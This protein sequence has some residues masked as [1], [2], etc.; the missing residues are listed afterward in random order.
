MQ[1]IS[2]ILFKPE[3]THILLLPVFWKIF[4]FPFPL[5]CSSQTEPPSASAYISTPP[6]LAGDYDFGD[7]W[8]GGASLDWWGLQH[9]HITDVLYQLLLNFAINNHS[10]N[11]LIPRLILT[12]ENLYQGRLIQ[13]SKTNEMSPLNDQRLSFWPLIISSYW[14]AAHRECAAYSY[15]SQELCRWSSSSHPSKW[16]L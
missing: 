13:V 2:H 10:S 14:N 7:C 4:I 15:Y 5:P 12:N 9:T 3:L 6:L 8:W 11:R 16:C 1:T